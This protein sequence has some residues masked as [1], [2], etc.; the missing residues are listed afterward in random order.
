MSPSKNKGEVQCQSDRTRTK[1]PHKE[2]EN[3]DQD[4]TCH[5]ANNLR[6]KML[7]STS[8]LKMEAKN[9]M[10][11]ILE[12]FFSSI[13]ALSYGEDRYPRLS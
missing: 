10:E 8:R 11:K 5:F 6:P 7:V 9:Q 3:E 4:A 1:Y 13:T 12:V 2:R